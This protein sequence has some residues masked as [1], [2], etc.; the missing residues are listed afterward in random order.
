M[1]VT[2]QTQTTVIVW[3]LEF[4]HQRRRG[5]QT[6]GSKILRGGDQ[7]GDSG[8]VPNSIVVT[9]PDMEKPL[10]TP[11]ISGGTSVLR[12]DAAT[13]PGTYIGAFEHTG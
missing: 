13:N 7:Y 9:L 6:D 12:Q 10:V 5:G 2:G 4:S 11:W 3:R 1:V 8:W